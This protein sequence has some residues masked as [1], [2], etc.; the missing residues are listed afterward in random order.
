MKVKFPAYNRKIKRVLFN[1][2]FG[3]M[4]APPPNDYSTTETMWCEN[5]RACSVQK[6]DCLHRWT[7]NQKCMSW[8]QNN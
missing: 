7:I 8:G 5:H 2:M 1:V 4:V 3:L 6:N